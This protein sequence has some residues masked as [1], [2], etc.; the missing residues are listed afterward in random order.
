[1]NVLIVY[2]HPEPTSFSAALVRRA[3]NAL[4]RAGHATTVSDLYAE[5][6]N[7][8]AG[9]HDFSTVADPRRFHY[10]SEQAL[11]ARSASFS[12]E[13]ARE[14]SRVSAADLLILQF[15]L[16]WGGP[17]AILKGWL[18]RVL[19]YGFGYVDGRRFETGVFKG[20]RA[21]LSVTTG[22]TTERFGPDGVYGELEKVLWQP[23]RLTL[24]YM[25]YTVEEP[26][27]AYAAPRVGN[28]ARAAYLD[29][30]EKRV[31]KAASQP[32]ERAD[33][34][35]LLAGVPEGAWARQR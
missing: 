30:F 9:R 32:V 13:I 2:A 35:D 10:Q 8:V 28:E 6:F 23:Q 33:P 18:E 12:P 20:R 11:A 17:P 14:Q 29:E 7:P 26:F 27:L 24:Q 4:E 5:K 25:G 22:G 19:A 34:E 3:K 1:M 21:M 16:W 15:P 31:L